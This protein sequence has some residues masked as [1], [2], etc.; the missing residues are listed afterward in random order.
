[1]SRLRTPAHVRLTESHS[2]LCVSCL[3]ALLTAVCA[4]ADEVILDHGYHF[5]QTFFYCGP[6]AIQ[7]MLDTP[8]VRNNNPSVVAL[9]TNPPPALFAHLTQDQWVQYQIYFNSRFRF[10]FGWLGTTPPAFSL[11]INAYDGI[12]NPPPLWPGIPQGGNPAHAYAWWGFAP[13][14]LCLAAG[15]ERRFR[16][17]PRNADLAMRTVA[18]AMKQFQVP[19]TVAVN[20][21]A[22]WLVVDG[23]RA[24]GVIGRN[25]P[26]TIREVRV[27]D[28]LHGL[29]Q[30]CRQPAPPPVLGCGGALLADR[31][32]FILG[33]NQW[34]SYGV[35]APDRFGCMRP[36][37]FLRFFNPAGPGPYPWSGQYVIVVEP[38]DPPPPAPPDDGNGGQYESL[39]DPAPMLDR[40]LERTELLETWFD[41]FLELDGA[42]PYKGMFLEGGEFVEDLAIF[43]SFPGEPEGW[44]DWVLPYDGPEPG[45]DDILGVLVLDAQTGVI[46]NAVRFSEDEVLTYD[47]L[48]EHYDNFYAMNWPNFDADFGPIPGDLNVDG[49]VDLADLSTLL[50]NFGLSGGVSYFDGDLDGDADV[51]LADLTI[52]LSNYLRGCAPV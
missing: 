6:A 17:L 7:M 47:Q 2:L 36:R 44:G 30:R 21:G 32:G 52:L 15:G 51:D 9:L 3:I 50:T 4:R 26:Y 45:H 27:S 33:R 13:D 31:A 10:N 20:T 16:R 1:M 41:I 22:H 8:A 42:S 29:V 19:A 25:Q 18:Y 11:T 23:V 28:P 40:P 14:A 46:D 35:N 43:R 38:D 49:C 5:Q 48:L 34:W 12:P 39:P 37:G 24:D